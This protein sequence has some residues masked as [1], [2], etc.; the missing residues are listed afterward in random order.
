MDKNPCGRT[1]G[2]NASFCDW[3]SKKMAILSILL[4]RREVN[5]CKGGDVG[6]VPAK[7]DE[8]RQ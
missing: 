7:H 5:A 8:P 6:R 3:A 1:T 4:I 2:N